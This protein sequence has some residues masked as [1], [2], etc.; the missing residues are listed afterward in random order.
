MM[1]ILYHSRTRI[2]NFFPIHLLIKPKL[3]DQW[4]NGLKR[5]AALINCHLW[6]NP[7]GSKI[8]NN[9]KVMP[10]NNG[11]NAWTA[12]EAVEGKIVI[13]NGPNNVAPSVSSSTMIAPKIGPRLE[14]NPPMI[15]IP[16]KMIES[17]K[18][19]VSEFK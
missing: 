2:D 10:K 9:I 13:K 19:K 4:E 18:L 1:I 5:Q 3:P 16:R 6:A 15:N 7:R 8:K 14:P 11:R 12:P 17:I